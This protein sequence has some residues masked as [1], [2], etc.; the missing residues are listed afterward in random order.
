MSSLGAQEKGC[1]KKTAH[2]SAI[3]FDPELVLEKLEK[4][5]AVPVVR[6]VVYVSK[7]HL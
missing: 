4:L 5:L 7:A 2:V 1:K 3:S 6:L